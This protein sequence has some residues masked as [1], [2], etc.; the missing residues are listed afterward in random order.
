MSICDKVLVTIKCF[1]VSIREARFCFGANKMHDAMNALYRRLAELSAVLANRGGLAVNDTV[2]DALERVEDLQHRELA[3]DL[4]RMAD[5]ELI[6]V[7]AAIQRVKDGTY[8]VC[9]E[10]GDQISAARLRAKQYATLCTGCQEELE[11]FGRG[12]SLA[13]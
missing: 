6:E 7:Q 11:M 5:R 1:P 8:G 4:L 13:A 10:C 3:S 12:D 9:E 2:A